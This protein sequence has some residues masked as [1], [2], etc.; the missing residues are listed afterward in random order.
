MRQEGLTAISLSWDPA[1]CTDPCA[2]VH[3]YD[4]VVESQV[5]KTSEPEPCICVQRVLQSLN[6]SYPR[7]CELS[8]FLAIRARDIEDIRDT[9]C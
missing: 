9:A 7:R 4:G 6:E 5:C 3:E 2:S 8:C 1:V